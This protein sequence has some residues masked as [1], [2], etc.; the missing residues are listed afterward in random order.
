[1]AID[2]STEEL[3]PWTDSE[4]LSGGGTVTTTITVGPQ[5]RELHVRVNATFNWRAGNTGASGFVPAAADTWTRVWTRHG[6]RDRRDYTIEVQAASGS[7]VY[8]SAQGE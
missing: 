7:V 8:I 1:M 2:I 3:R 6:N 4:T 5:D